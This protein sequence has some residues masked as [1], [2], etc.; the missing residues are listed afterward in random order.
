MGISDRSYRYRVG[1]T[2]AG[3]IDETGIFGNSQLFKASAVNQ[4]GFSL[5]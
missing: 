5:K 4:M 3:Q 1:L 2:S